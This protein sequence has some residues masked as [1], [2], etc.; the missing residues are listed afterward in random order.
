M[1]EPVFATPI[2]KSD[3]CYEFTKE[4]LDCLSSLELMENRG[5]TVTK[6]KNIF[7]NP[8]LSDLRNWCLAN[9]NA[10][11]EQLG[12]EKGVEFYITNSWYNKSKPH[13]SHHSH[14]HPNSIFSAVLYV[15][16][17][18]VPTFFYNNGAFAN[19]TFYDKNKGNQ[20]TANKVGIRNEPGRLVL[21][22][23]S[24]THDVDTNRGNSDRHTIS[25]NTF[26]KGKFGD[27]ND[28]TELTI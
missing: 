5:N 12:K 22:P 11:A 21:F 7:N 14:M 18:D 1:I 15:D 6:D 16:G 3:N 13:E 20:F 4:Q 26:I 28:L 8:I 2:Y 10:F 27:Y 17:P 25:F 9:V 19:F 23:S 24:L